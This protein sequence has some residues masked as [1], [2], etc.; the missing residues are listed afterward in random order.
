MNQE[1][2]DWVQKTFGLEPRWTIEPNI[3]A[4]ESLARK[5]LELTKSASCKVDLY[6]QGG[7]NKIYRICT[8]EDNFLMRVSLPVDPYY[9]VMSEV[10]T[11]QLVRK[12]T[13]MPVPKIFA[14]D[15]S[16]KNELGFEWILMEM[17]PGQPLRSHWRELTLGAKQDLVRS[18]AMYLGRLFRSQFHGIGNIFEKPKLP[19]PKGPL[20][21]ASTTGIED[22]LDFVL[23]RIVSL[24]FFWG[25][26][27]ARDFPRGPFAKSC[28]WL[29]ARL[30]F[31]LDDQERILKVSDDE[32][33]V[34]EAENVRSLATR[35]VKLMPQVFPSY[36]PL[37]EL[38][39]IFHDDLSWQNILVNDSGRLVAIIDWE[40]V[41]ALPLWKSCQ[42]PAF[43]EGRERDEEPLRD[44]YSADETKDMSGNELSESSLDNGGV[45]SLYWEHLL[46]YERTHLR[47]V[48][49]AEME[50]IEPLW[51]EVWKSSSLKADFETA[52]RN[53][54]NGFCF[55][56][57]SAWLDDLEHGETWDL[58]RRLTQ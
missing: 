10:A 25:D 42:V 20:K 11:I 40:C 27:L 15:A 32:D 34:E 3:E 4:V 37:I 58:R 35:L 49:M 23:G 50:K 18:V 17:M 57:I 13:G 38:S 41:S 22:D 30:A 26:H 19:V 2:L 14:F 44:S 56:I 48:F 7:F 39:T 54:D 9:K 12:N 52:V 28:D 6:A 46:E 43:L 51:L 53:C 45:N 5:H 29:S 36:D 24:E 16:N 55:K 8:E 1:G 21:I 33:D 31:T 47:Q